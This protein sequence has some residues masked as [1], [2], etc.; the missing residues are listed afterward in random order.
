MNEIF[1]IVFNLS[2]LG[3]VSGGMITLGLGLTVAQIIAPFKK[4]RIVIRALVVPLL[5]A[6]VGI[7][8]LLPLAIINGKNCTS[9][10]TCAK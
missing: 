4:I 2:M 9:A 6:I 3:F 10:R 1:E 5:V 7:L 8:I